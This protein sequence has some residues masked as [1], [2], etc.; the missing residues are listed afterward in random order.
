[1]API[2]STDLCPH[3]LCCDAGFQLSVCYLLCCVFLVS[4]FDKIQ[5]RE[6]E[7]TNPLLLRKHKRSLDSSTLQCVLFNFKRFLA[8]GVCTKADS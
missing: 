8:A 7:V 5:L 6:E 2:C 3:M 4:F 1:M